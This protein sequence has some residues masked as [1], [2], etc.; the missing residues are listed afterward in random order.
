M[1]INYYKDYV[2]Y[3]IP[4][5]EYKFKRSKSIIEKD[6]I[7]FNEELESTD[8]TYKYFTVK[9]GSNF[10]IR[11]SSQN[12]NEKKIFRLDSLYKS[13]G[14]DKVN[15]EIYNIKYFNPIESKKNAVTKKIEFEKFIDKNEYTQLGDTIY[16]FYNPSL[17]WVEFS[18]ADEIEREKKT[19]LCKYV[20]I[21]LNKV[22][23]G[24]INPLKTELSLEIANKK[25]PDSV[26]LYSLFQLFETDI[27]TPLFLKR[28]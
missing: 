25:N 4:I 18:I 12:N 14:I 11:Y 9:K 10:G 3:Q 22:N 19:K 23:K 24:E 13:L 1:Y 17:N 20:L 7:K 16:R 28:H 15:M 5:L 26:K 27:K 2:I 6:T 21:Q 8:T